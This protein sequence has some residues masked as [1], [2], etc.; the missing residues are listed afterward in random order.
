MTDHDHHLTPGRDAR[1]AG[2]LL[3]SHDMKDFKLPEGDP[4][5][6]GWDVRTADG[7]KLGK[8]EDLMVDT[9][10]GRVRYL[11]V[12]V[13]KDVVKAGGREYALVP[14]GSARLDDDRDDVVVSLS[15][16]DL[17][18]I[19]AY[20]RGNVSREYE[21]SLR[22]FVRDRPARPGTADP[23]SS[24]AGSTGASTTGIPTTG[25]PITG[26]A[27]TGAA[28]STGSDT[29]FYTGAEYDDRSFFGSRRRGTAGGI[30]G[31]LADAADDMKDRI[32]GDPRSRP[33]PDATDRPAR[34]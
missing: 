2:G 8:V 29:D 7:Q 13:D 32:D 20:E 26:S 4:D 24:Y 10:T 15:V 6:R 31:R 23:T 34:H 18:G 30:G 22:T 16:A 3:H 21:Q 28:A 14:V 9:G 11:E 25:I 33:G 5:P 19:P 12:A 27:V 17:T 1:S